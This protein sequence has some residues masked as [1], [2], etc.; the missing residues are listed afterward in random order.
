MKAFYR[1]ENENL[2]KIYDEGQDWK[3]LS[4]DKD[5][6]PLEHGENWFSKW[7]A[8]NKVKESLFNAV[9]RTCKYNGIEY[10]PE[11]VVIV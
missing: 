4:A 8:S 11:K 1:D 6:Y 2:L 5:G 7:Y 10:K 9:E 3:V